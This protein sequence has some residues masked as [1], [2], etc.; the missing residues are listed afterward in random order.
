MKE[1]FISTED[2]TI[3]NS[4]KNKEQ[5]INE[6]DKNKKVVVFRSRSQLWHTLTSSHDLILILIVL[7][8]IPFT[9]KKFDWS[10]MIGIIFFMIID[11]GLIWLNQYLLGLIPVI[12]NQP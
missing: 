10:M 4:I 8:I 11:A 2:S 12:L 5:F 1:I 3:S 6:N 9:E 7:P